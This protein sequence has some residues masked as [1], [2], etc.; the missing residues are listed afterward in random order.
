MNELSFQAMQWCD[1]SSTAVSRYKTCSALPGREE[2]S[3]IPH[4][5]SL[6]LSPTEKGHRGRPPAKGGVAGFRRGM[7]LCSNSHGYEL[8]L[9][10]ELAPWDKGVAPPGVIRPVY[11]ETFNLPPPHQQPL[12]VILWRLTS[13]FCHNCIKSKLST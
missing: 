1:L 11:A 3:S 8:E 13:V 6:P 9:P 4:W 10:A 5:L 7:Q 12:P 2:Q